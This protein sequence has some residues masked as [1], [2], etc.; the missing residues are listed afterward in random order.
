MKKI[1]F[2]NYRFSEDLDFTL[3]KEASTDPRDI[4]K[5]L[6]EVSKI[7][8]ELFGFTIDQKSIN[9]SPF[10]D[11]NGL[12][13]QIKIPFQSPLLAS[14]SLPKIKL[15]LSKNEELVDKEKFS[16]LMHDYS[17]KKD[18]SV[19]IRNYSMNEIFSEKCR[20]LVERTRP[21]DL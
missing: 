20:A 16:P 10:P 13:I 5:Y 8:Y 18:V 12:F 1:Y 4:H 17:D 2:K 7:G 3:K 14:G 15:D 19:Q 11:K 9:I 21:R 6:L